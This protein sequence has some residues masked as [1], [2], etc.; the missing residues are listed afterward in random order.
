MLLAL[1]ATVAGDSG[2]S[3][4]GVS[5]GDYSGEAL[6]ALFV[7]LVFLG[8]WVPRSQV[9]MWQQSAQR[10]ADQVDTLIKSI[11]P[12]LAYIR[13]KQEETDRTPKQ[14]GDPT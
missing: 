6:A 1:A 7:I 9:K 12:V 4:L 10:S 2:I 14:G 13:Q 11:E 3:V 8:V 5:L